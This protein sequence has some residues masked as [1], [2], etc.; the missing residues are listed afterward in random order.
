[1]GLLLFY[2][3]NTLGVLSLVTTS[4]HL[5]SAV[6]SLL[7]IFGKCGIC[8][9]FANCHPAPLTHAVSSLRPKQLNWLRYHT[10]AAQVY[11]FLDRAVLAGCACCDWCLL[12]RSG[13]SEDQWAA[14][15]AVPAGNGWEVVRTQPETLWSGFQWGEGSYMLDYIEKRQKTK[16]Q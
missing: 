7:F 13:R 10:S 9:A 14:G 3:K 11:P 12:C 4:Q 5:T 16:V 2:R 8:S 6:V 1:M 15:A